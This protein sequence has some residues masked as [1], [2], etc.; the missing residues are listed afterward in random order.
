MIINFFHTGY[1]LMIKKNYVVVSLQIL[2]ICLIILTT[3]GAVNYYTNHKVRYSRSYNDFVTKIT[4]RDY[5]QRLRSDFPKKYIGPTVDQITEY[6]EGDTLISYQL[7]GRYGFMNLF[8]GE[9]AIPS[10][11]HHFKYAWRFD[12]QSGLA[13][14]IDENGKIGF[15]TKEG[16]YHIPPSYF[17]KLESE[18]DP[19]EFKDGFC[20]I[21]FF[22]NNSHKKFGLINTENQ[23]V[24]QPEYDFIGESEEGYR[25]I[26]IN[27]KYGLAGR[28]GTIIIQPIY[29][30]IS[31][32]MLGI[33]VL[34][35]PKNSQVL[36][37]FD[38]KTVLAKAFDEIT[39]IETTSKSENPDESESEQ[40]LTSEDESMGEFPYASGYSTFTVNERVGIIRKS[41]G[42]IIIPPIYDG[43]YLFSDHLFKAEINEKYIL[44]D[45]QGQFVQ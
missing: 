28:T 9:D 40:E 25:V 1:T 8:T 37:G 31:I 41:D 11:D 44:I 17:F 29:D 2:A 42:K 23:F 38:F 3:L 30:A 22:S 4:F 20:I 18:E 36:L 33:I 6:T 34:D 14:V 21:P 12:H 35:A 16:K 10:S 24:I 26:E 15:I 43:I 7:K 39:P 19:I 45:D 13:A 32:N 5:K 27:G